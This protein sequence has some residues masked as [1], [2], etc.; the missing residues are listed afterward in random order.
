MCLASLM[1][2]G[3]FLQEKPDS[4]QNVGVT[5]NGTSANIQWT[6]SFNGGFPQTFI[7]LAL[8]KEKIGSQSETIHDRGENVIHDT[9]LQ[10]LEQP[11]RYVFYIIAQ[12]KIGNSSSESAQ[13]P[14]FEGT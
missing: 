13:C 11:T 8:Y 10:D 4:P 6:S 7:A 1:Y 9:Q 2:F 14:T 12:N 3:V 5:C